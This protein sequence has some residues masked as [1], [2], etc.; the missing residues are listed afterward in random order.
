MARHSHFHNIQLTKGKADAARA[1]VFSKYAK[2]ITA[3]AKEGGQDASF[4]FKLRMAIEAAKAVNMPKDNIERAV[5]R[6]AGGGEGA[7]IE[8]VI[9]EGF[10]PGGVAVL[11][12]CLTNNRNR[13]IGDIKNIV[14]KAGGSI[15]N[16]GSVIWMFEKKGVVVFSSPPTNR[17]SFE[18]AMIDAGAEDIIFSDDGLLIVCEVKDLKKIVEA[19][20]ALG[21][22]PDCAGIE[23]IAKKTT[24]VTDP[25][26][27]EQIKKFV[28]TIEEN[29]D[30]DAVFTN[31]K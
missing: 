23:F 14:S 30:V 26:I 4:N 20:E 28:E 31:R 8:E 2:S 3:A 17:D 29:D 7:N 24:E 15:G 11:I 5:A 6:G 16:Q 9:Y 21:F 12:R 22:K 25:A 19:V 18:L 13:T 1:K 27:Q 10:G